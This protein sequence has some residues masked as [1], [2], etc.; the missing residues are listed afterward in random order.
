MTRWS[1]ITRNPAAATPLPA[2]ASLQLRDREIQLLQ[3]MAAR[4]RG[5][6]AGLDIGIVAYR[7]RDHLR[8]SL[9]SVERHMS[10]GIHV[11]VVDSESRDGTVEPARGEFPSVR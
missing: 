4:F 5:P 1:A 9:A 6:V 11:W 2:K 8:C 3:G 10:A 7:C